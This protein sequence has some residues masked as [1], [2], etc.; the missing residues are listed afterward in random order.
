MVTRDGNVVTRWFA[1]RDPHLFALKRATRLAVVMPLNFAIGSVV[2]GSAEVATL[3]AFGSFALLL[4]VEFPG[5]RAS[6]ASAYGLLAG[7]GAVLITLG[8]L[9]SRQVWVA[10]ASMAVV[11]FLVL[12]AGSISSV[13]ALAGRA[14]LLTF[15]LPVMFVGSAADVPPRL[16]GWGIACAVAIPA[17]LFIWP[18]QDQNQLRV[19]TATMC[20]VTAH[21]ID[22]E[23]ADEPTES[24]IVAMRRALADL[25]MAFRAS[26]SRPVA[27]STG[28]RL[29]IRLVDELEWLTTTVENTCADPPSTWPEQAARLRKAAS[30]VLH[31]CATVLE[32]NGGGPTRSGCRR[33]DEQIAILRET[34]QAVHAE[35]LAE[36]RASTRPGPEVPAAGDFERPLYAAHE[37]G[38]LVDQTA[39]TVSVIAAAD[40]RSWSARLIGRSATSDVLGEAAAAERIAVDSFG[41]NSVW[42]QNAIRG[43]VGLAFAVL[44]ARISG[45]QEGFWIVLGALSVLRSNALTTGT[46]ALRAVAGTAVGFV[47]GGLLVAAIG[48]SPDVLWPLLPIVVLIAAFTPETVSFA[49]GQAAFTVTIIILF[50]IIAPAGWRI[51][52]LRVEDVAIGCL[53]GV[54]AG[55]LFWPRGAGA[56]LGSAFADAY[57][58]AAQHMREAINYATGRRPTAPDRRGMAMSA[59]LRM[60]AALRQYLAERGAKRVPLSSVTALANGATQLRLAGDAIAELTAISPNGGPIALEAPVAV[61]VDQTDRVTTWYSD[62]A[63]VLAGSSESVPGLERT[64]ATSFLDVVLPAIY[65]CGD[66]DRAEQAERLLWSGQYL[67]DVTRMRAELVE[68]AQD[69][70][71]TRMRSAWIRLAPDGGSTSPPRS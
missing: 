71:E 41:R 37:L 33:L 8:T 48:T 23:A 14:A 9:L 45:Q 20:H 26:A 67:G 53:A 70:H 55:A 36:L 1:A 28:S 30:T 2:I 13:I 60:D 31:C 10:A 21:V 38:Y 22:V 34:R 24:P 16:L 3:A 66:P 57:W 61:L 47:I 27:L 25:R 35:T 40:S 64:R 7:L 17:A 49:V 50:N 69:V 54:V 43:A 63:D 52:V 18:P 65:G 32:H 15:I 51:G 4:F 29:L 5:N 11:G 59:S 42:L 58:S 44:L 56:A 62:L 46:T 19:R 12:F 39:T 68:P 6:R